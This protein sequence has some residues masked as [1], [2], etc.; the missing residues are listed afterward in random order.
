M[1]SRGNVKSIGVLDGLGQTEIVNNKNVW[2]RHTPIS[3]FVKNK[4]SEGGETAVLSLQKIL[5]S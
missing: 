2:G 3:D 1:R 4:G 5:S